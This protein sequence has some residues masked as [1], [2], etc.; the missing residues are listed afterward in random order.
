MEEI[1]FWYKQIND[2]LC[3]NVS[4][5]FCDWTTCTAIENA[6]YNACPCSKMNGKTT[7]AFEQLISF[8]M[9]NSELVLDLFRNFVLDGQKN[10]SALCNAIDDRSF[11]SITDWNVDLVSI[12]ITG[13][14]TYYNTFISSASNDTFYCN[15]SSFL[16]QEQSTAY[17]EGAP[18]F[19]TSD[20]IDPIAV[21]IQLPIDNK[22]ITVNQVN[23]A[24]CA[25]SVICLCPTVHYPL[26]TYTFENCAT[27]SLFS[28]Q[29]IYASTCRPQGGSA[30]QGRE[31]LHS[32][33]IGLKFAGE[34]SSVLKTT[35]SSCAAL[36]VTG[37]QGNNE[38][39]IK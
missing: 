17:C 30:S 28:C 26:P 37:A 27:S 1:L 39:Y 19:Y 4:F 38:V 6:T 14:K 3:A 9:I 35:S 29:D 10:P 23:Q 25:D 2:F 7:V 12:P 5:A 34:I 18:C 11:F 31:A 15:A 21:E 20:N 13:H 33:Y 36:Q 32:M 22:T 24:T 16:S 8:A